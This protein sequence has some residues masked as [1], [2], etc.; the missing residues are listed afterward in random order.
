MV[1]KRAMV[2][3]VLNVDVRSEKIAFDA[4]LNTLFASVENR[5]YDE[6][7][8]TIKFLHIN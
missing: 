8:K 4:G 2:S 3:K 6:L 1:E 7:N 5:N